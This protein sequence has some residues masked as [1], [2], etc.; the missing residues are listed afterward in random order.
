MALLTLC[1]PVQANLAELNRLSADGSLTTFQ[2]DSASADGGLTPDLCTASGRKLA[3]TV[4]ETW[5]LLVG[6]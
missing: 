3:P 5:I 4:M 2:E 6:L 1:C